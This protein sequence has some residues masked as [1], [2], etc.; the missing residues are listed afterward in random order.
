MISPLQN[1]LGSMIDEIVRRV[2]IKIS[3]GKGGIET[4]S[5][6]IMDGLG[7]PRKSKGQSNM[8]FALEQLS[9]KIMPKLEEIISSKLDN[10]DRGK[11]PFEKE[12]S[13]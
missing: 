13:K 1:V 6:K 7:I 10:I 8:D 2:W 9:N 3:G 5:G 12:W 11:V 4:Q